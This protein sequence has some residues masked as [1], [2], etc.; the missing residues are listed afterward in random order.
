M[1]YYKKLQKQFIKRLKPLNVLFLFKNRPWSWE[2]LYT[3]LAPNAVDD[4]YFYLNS[5][6]S[7]E[8]VTLMP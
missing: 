5:I 1:R 2:R 8:T 4:K 3:V 7:T 6:T